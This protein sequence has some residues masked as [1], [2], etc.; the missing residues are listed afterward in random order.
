MT[1]YIGG[2]QSLPVKIT[3]SD[4]SDSACGAFVQ[5]QPGVE[6]CLTRTGRSRSPRKVQ[7]GGNFRLHASR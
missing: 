5:L 7:R 6:L 1:K 4:A 2:A 3:F